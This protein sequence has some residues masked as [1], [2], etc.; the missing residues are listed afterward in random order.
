MELELNAI[1]LRIVGCLM[2]KEI[3]TP[4]Y[5]PLTLNQLVAAC[6]QKSNRHPVMELDERTIERTLEDLREGHHLACRIHTS[7][8]RV[9]KYNHTL[10]DQWTF[11]PQEFA[12]LC[13]LFL[14]GPQ[15]AGELRTHASRICPMNDL[16]E[17]EQALQELSVRTDGPFTAILPREPGKREQR[18]THLFS[19]TAV[20]TVSAQENEGGQPIPQGPGLCERVAALEGEVATLRETLNQIQNDYA[21]FKRQFS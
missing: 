20:Q 6:N 16:S 11:S 1:E 13:E 8:S 12:I 4:D 2:E 3:T 5:Y 9:P 18:W 14:R 15:T 19:G 21:E 17:V 7:G 10:A